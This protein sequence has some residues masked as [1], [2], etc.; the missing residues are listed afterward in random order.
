MQ[1][2]ESR[3]NR[4]NVGAEDCNLTWNKPT[5]EECIFDE[6]QKSKSPGWQEQGLPIIILL[7]L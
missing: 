6:I 7:E 5:S 4:F 2:E 1:H 3:R